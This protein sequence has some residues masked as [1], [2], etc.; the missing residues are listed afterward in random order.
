MITNIEKQTYLK[1]NKTP[2]KGPI[3]YNKQLKEG[4]YHP[5]TDWAVMSIEH[6]TM[7]GIVCDVM[8]I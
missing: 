1:D 2:G 4:T 5:L 6:I 3:R 8:T 7:Q